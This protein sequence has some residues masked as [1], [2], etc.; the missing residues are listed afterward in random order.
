MNHSHPSA[1]SG[2]ST[3]GMASMLRRNGPRLALFAVVCTALIVVTDYFTRDQIARQ[4]EQQLQRTLGEMLPA[5]SYDN[6]LAQSC[7][8]VTSSGYLGDNKQHAVYVGRH[9]GT[10]TGYV[11]DSMAAGGYSGAI[12]LLTAVD[13]QGTVT[14]VQVLEHHETPGLGDKIERSKSNWIDR[15]TGQHL[16]GAD[17]NRWAVRKDGGMY[18]SFTGA[19]I[20]PRAVVKGVRAVLLML[21]QHPELIEQAPACPAGEP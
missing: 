15:F 18:D 1:P 2:A 21:Q 3:E 14:R 5:G 6:N 17:D 16:Q 13:K 4:A 7:V 20:T 9:N 10:P 11:V 8:L 19:T 12:H